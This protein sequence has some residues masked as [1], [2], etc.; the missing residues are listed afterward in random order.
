MYD[1]GGGRTRKLRAHTN[2]RLLLQMGRRVLK[3][4]TI[5]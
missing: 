1:R 5:C 4:K 2:V 3:I